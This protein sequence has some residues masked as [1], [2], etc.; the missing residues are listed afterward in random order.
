MW[1]LQYIWYDM[2]YGGGGG[3]TAISQCNSTEDDT[4]GCLYKAMSGDKNQWSKPLIGEMRR[5]E[6]NQEKWGIGKMRAQKQGKVGV[7]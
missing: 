6:I 2:M 1:L 4:R 5:W 7:M 3:C